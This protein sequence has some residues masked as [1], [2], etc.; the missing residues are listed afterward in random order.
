VRVRIG[1]DTGQP[2]LSDEGYVGLDVH[3]AAPWEL[4]R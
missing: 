1:I 3:R 4:A 2:Q